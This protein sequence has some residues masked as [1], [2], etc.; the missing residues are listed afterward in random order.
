MSHRNA[1]TLVELLIVIA[2]VAIVMTSVM[3]V[4]NPAELL[5]QSRDANR[6][7]DLATINKSIGLY[8]STV[9]SLTGAAATIYV[10]IPDSA[11][12]STA[13]DQC[14]GLGLAT[15][16]AGW[17][18]HCAASSTYRRTNGTGW[19]P[20]DFDLIPTGAISVL[21]IDPVNTT[22]TNEYY[23]YVTTGTGDWALTMMPESQQYAARALNDGGVDPLRFEAG[24][25]FS[26]ISGAEGL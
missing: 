12:T 26:L 11:A 10:S 5:R 1:F 15:P 6:F 18:Y 17:K 3:F 9:S 19:L 24:T 22:S 14:Q 8:A 4:V 13:G 16:P 20:I 7:T 23:I 21:P 2:I 25:N